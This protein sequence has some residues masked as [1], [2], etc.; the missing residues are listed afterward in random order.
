M[1]R[2]RLCVHTPRPSYTHTHACVCTHHTPYTHTM[3]V[4]TL[5]PPYTHTHTHTQINNKDSP[6]YTK[7]YSVFNMLSV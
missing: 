1:R 7:S 2:E 4:Y 5:R 6:A 3:C